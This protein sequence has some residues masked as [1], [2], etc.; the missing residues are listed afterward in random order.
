MIQHVQLVKRHKN[1]IWSRIESKCEKC[2]PPCVYHIYVLYIHLHISAKWGVTNSGREWCVFF[3]WPPGPQISNTH[4]LKHTRVHAVTMPRI[5]RQTITS[6]E[7]TNGPSSFLRPV[8]L[9][10]IRKNIH[11]S[12]KKKKKEMNTQNEK[13]TKQNIFFLLWCL[14]Q[15]Q[16]H[17]AQR[18]P[19]RLCRY[20]RR[21]ARRR[22]CCRRHQTTVSRG[23]IMLCPCRWMIWLRGWRC[24]LRGAPWVKI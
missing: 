10:Q 16:H 17:S 20:P 1:G 9:S 22:R 18:L 5:T 8:L 21:L 24:A 2:K 6:E 23:L 7:T 15:V 3:R 13:R 4:Q 19:D 11:H 14:S 12:W